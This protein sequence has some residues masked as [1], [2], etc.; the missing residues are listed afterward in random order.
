MRSTQR[1]IDWLSDAASTILRLERL[2]KRIHRKGLLAAAL[3]IQDLADALSYLPEATADDIARQLTREFI[4]G[5]GKGTLHGVSEI[6][7]AEKLDRVAGSGGGG[8][9]PAGVRRA[10]LRDDDT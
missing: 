5:Y 10:G 1:S 3:R 9:R 6:Q 2:A 7:L 8:D 4:N